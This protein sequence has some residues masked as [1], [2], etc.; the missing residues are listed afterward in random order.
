MDISPPP[1][2]HTRGGGGGGRIDPT[3]TFILKWID[4]HRVC[5]T[6]RGAVIAPAPERAIQRE[7]SVTAPPALVEF[8]SILRGDF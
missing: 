3:A 2:Q 1:P 5:N 8:A 7:T 4:T 6:D